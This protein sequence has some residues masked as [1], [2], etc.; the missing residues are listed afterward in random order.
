MPYET[1]RSSNATPQD[2]SSKMGERIAQY[3]TFRGM[4]LRALAEAAGLSSSFLSQLE[5]GRT[6][7]SVASLHKIADALGV[8]LGQLFEDGKVHTTG[9]LRAE[10]RPTLP[11]EGGKK[12]VISRLPLKN[13]EVYAGEFAPGATTGPHGYVHGNSQEFFIVTEGTI[14]FELDAERYEMSKGDSIEFLS[15]VPHRAENL[16]TEMAEVIW[17]T[18]PPSPDEEE[19]A[20]HRMA[21]APE[22]PTE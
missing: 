7:A 14:I 4:S 12:Y 8:A 6:N 11:L 3:R 10:D 22:A 17:I 15:S 21:A 18:S 16:S 20:F 13:V 9:V 19:V 5:N 1:P 2:I